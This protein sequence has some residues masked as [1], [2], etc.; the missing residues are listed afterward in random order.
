MHACRTIEGSTPSRRGSGRIALQANP[1]LGDDRQA[2]LPYH[3][4][5]AAALASA[6]RG[7][8]DPPP[9]QASKAKLRAQALAWLKAELVVW[10]KLL[11]GGD[12]KVR[13]QVD[14]TL[15]GWKA[16]HRPDC[17]RSP[18]ALA[19]LPEAERK[20]WQALWAD[21]DALLKLAVPKKP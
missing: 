12:P 7:K 4:A 16:R 17:L 8:D 2:K 3:A 1:K 11:D 15:E 13:A 19:K 20:E 21:V 5:G 14:Q 18:Q 6:G 10:A 9:D